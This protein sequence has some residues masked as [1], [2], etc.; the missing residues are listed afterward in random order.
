MIERI[1]KKILNILSDENDSDEQ[2]EILLFGITRIVEDVPKYIAII[3][4]C[5]V[6]G[7]IKEFAIV[8]VVTAI[9]KTFTGGVHLHTN[10]GCF[11]ASLVSILA[12]IYLPMLLVNYDKSI[13]IVS[14]FTYIFSVYCILVYIPA[15]VP[16]IPIINERRRKRD[17]IM[18][19]VILNLLF[20]ISFLIIK[21]NICI[22]T[23]MITILSIDIMTTRTIYKIF[24]NQYGYETYV[25]D[26]LLI[27]D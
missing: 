14:V 12:C 1:S 27:I 24:K 23:I 15:D 16:E 7:I 6:L 22:L 21:N 10:I 9:Y 18:S 25:P 11:I 17:R 3:V 20:V 2:K 26:E 5:I 19:F 8:M 13:M 4:I